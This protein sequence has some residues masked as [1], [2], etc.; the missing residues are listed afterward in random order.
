MVVT[1]YFVLAILFILCLVV[2]WFAVFNWHVGSFD[3]LDSDSIGGDFF[4]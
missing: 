1:F 3:I 4:G 2:F